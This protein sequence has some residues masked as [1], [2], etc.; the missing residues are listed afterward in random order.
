MVNN[1]EMTDEG[2]RNET[3]AGARPLMFDGDIDMRIARDGTWYYQGT[4]IKRDRLVRLFASVLMR[5][6]HGD[7]FL[8]TPV[9]RARIE[10]EDAPFVAV[11]MTREGEGQSQT[12]TFRSNL[13]ETVEVGADHPLRVAED[14]ESGEPSPYVEIRDG[15]EA[16]LT[17]SVY[18]DLA[19]L[20]EPAD[21]DP[22]CLGVWSG[23]L[24]FPLGPAR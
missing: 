24:F 14:P 19:E 18:Y 21:E 8:K 1:E 11:E 6:E 3:E 9:E 7:F 4:P 22:D 5:D 15:L 20:A 12:L 13:D 16:L 10:V 2:T 17:R 23:G